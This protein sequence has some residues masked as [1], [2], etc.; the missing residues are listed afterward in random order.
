[1]AIRLVI[2][3]NQRQEKYSLSE[4]GVSYCTDGT[5]DKDFVNP[6]SPART[7]DLDLLRL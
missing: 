7:A 6:P 1:M 5:P 2:S 4:V 3:N